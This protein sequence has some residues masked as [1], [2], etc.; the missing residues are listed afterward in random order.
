[1]HWYCTS[2]VRVLPLITPPEDYTTLGHL[3]RKSPTGFCGAY[4]ISIQLKYSG[5]EDKPKLTEGCFMG[6]KSVY[7]DEAVDSSTLAI[8]VF[9]GSS[10]MNG[11]VLRH[12]EDVDWLC[13]GH[14]LTFELDF[15]AGL[16]FVSKDGKMKFHEKMFLKKGRGRW[17]NTTCSMQFFAH[18]PIVGLDIE[19]VPDPPSVPNYSFTL[20]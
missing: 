7:D 13:P 2:E 12:G 19:I 15:D 6:V 5:K 14:V 8:D 4:K 16:I 11:N 20:D 10:F 3:N 1:L 17:A 9:N 18:V